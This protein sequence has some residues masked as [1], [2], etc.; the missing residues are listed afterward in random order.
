MLDVPDRDRDRWDKYGDSDGLWWVEFPRVRATRSS[1][2]AARNRASAI[3]ALIWD[4]PDYCPPPLVAP[5]PGFFA[6]D[7]ETEDPDMLTRGPSWAFENRGA[8]LGMSVAW[9]GFEAYYSFAH[10]EGNVDSGPVFRWL[11]STLRR[12]DIEVVCA[13]AAY[14]IGWLR[15]QLGVYPSCRIGDVQFMGAL[16]DENRMSYALDA[17]CKS[18][19]GVGKAYNTIDE[20]ADRVLCKRGEV[21]SHLKELP[22]KVVAPYAIPDATLT[23]RLHETL[24]PKIVAEGLLPV[25]QLECDLIP[26]SIEM[27]RRGVRV[28]VDGAERLLL[29]YRDRMEVIKSQLLDATQVNVEPWE[30]ESCA[31]ALESRGHVLPRTAQGRASVTKEILAELAVND[32]VA[33]SILLLRKLSK[34]CTTFLEGHILGYADNGVIHPT[35]NQLRRDD[36]EQGASMRGTVSGRYSVD[37]PNIQQLPIRNP[38]IGHAIRSLFLPWQ[39]DKWCALDYSSQEPRI[40]VEFAYRA[41]LTGAAETIAAYQQNPRLDMHQWVADLCG[42]DRKQAKT[43]NLGRSYGMASKALARNLGLPTKI[44]AVKGKKWMDTTPENRESFRRDGY[45]IVEIG[46]DETQTLIRKWERHAPFIKE[47]IELAT[48]R[49]D[50]RGFVQ[51]ILKRRCR[52]QAKGD[53]TYWWTHASA[54][55]I[56][57]GSAADQMKSAMLLMWREGV[58]PILTLHDEIGASVSDDVEPLRLKEIMETALPGFSIPFICDPSIG[59]NW[60]LAKH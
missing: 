26:L 25:Y 6:L 7:L 30:G 31:A 46:G 55:R 15:R 56:I 32:S 19:L 39:G 42:I 49:A 9:R 20:V 34:A 22:A 37:S 8:I 43:I 47:F 33:S 60:A 50:S 51:T 28:D 14:D 57:Q 12:S 41:K 23:Y 3:R 48:Y 1:E 10:S 16:L 59:D 2:E 36:N 17:L 13:H 18:F 21:F 52:F 27:R 54:N 5:P 44:M 4:A 24:M 58:V 45:E 38:D 53:G 35:Y 11:E 29:D 40:L